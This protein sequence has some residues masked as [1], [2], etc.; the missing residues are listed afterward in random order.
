MRSSKGILIILVTLSSLLMVASASM[1]QS[2]APKVEFG[3]RAGANF[4]NINTDQ[5]QSSKRSGLV[6]GVYAD[7][8]TLLLHLQAEALISQHGFKGGTPLSN[9]VGN[10]KLEYR[11]TVLQIPALVVLALPSP[12]VSPRAY[13]GP[14]LNIPL[15]SEMKLDNDW[16]DIKDDTKT[17]WS[18]VFGVGVKIFRV[19]VDLRYSLGLSAFNDRPVGQILDDAFNEITG[20][21]QYDDVKDHTLSITASIALN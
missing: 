12:M 13:I 8:S 10:S 5:I 9:Y 6:G 1:A 21:D 2:P 14:A 7:L 3:V 17:S 16:V 20:V 11:D 15:K 18:M 19:G 4:S